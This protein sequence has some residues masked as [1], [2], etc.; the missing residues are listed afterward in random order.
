MATQTTTPTQQNAWVSR[1][2]WIAAILLLGF[3]LGFATDYISTYLPDTLQT[4]HAWLPNISALAWSIV[5]HAT[6]DTAAYDSAR[7][8]LALSAMPLF[9]AGATVVLARRTNS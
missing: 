4:I 8:A 7:S 2:I 9:L 6:R 5:D 3:E 1:I